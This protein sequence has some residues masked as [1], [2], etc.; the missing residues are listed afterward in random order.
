ML[1]TRKS[2]VTGTDNTLDIPLTPEQLDIYL[3]GKRDVQEFLPHLTKDQREFLITG[4]TA[5]DWATLGDEEE[6]EQ[7]DDDV[8]P[9]E[10]VY[11]DDDDDI[12]DDEDAEEARR[13]NDFRALE[14]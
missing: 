13:A 8:G 10:D 5:E 6:S 4:C 2:P 12:L 11:P 9:D 7:E 1:I 14:D 3:E